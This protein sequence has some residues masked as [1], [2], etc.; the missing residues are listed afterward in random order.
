KRG[1]L[2]SSSSESDGVAFYI[3]L[4][5]YTSTSEFGLNVTW[6]EIDCG[7]NGLP[8]FTA[9][10]DGTYV[11]NQTSRNINAAYGN[12]QGVLL[13]TG[14]SVDL[15][16]SGNS[17][18]FPPLANGEKF[19]GWVK[20]P[21]A[22]FQTC[23]NSA[24][25]NGAVDFYDFGNFDLYF[26]SYPNRT[27]TITIDE[28][29]FY[30]PAF[31]QLAVECKPYVPEADIMN[32]S[33]NA[34]GTVSDLT[35]KSNISVVGTPQIG[36]IAVSHNG[37]SG[38]L[39]GLKIN[40]SGQGLI[41]TFPSLTTANAQKELYKNGFTVEAFAVNLSPSGEQGIIST[42]QNGGWGL[43]T[44]NADS[45]F[46]VNTANSYKECFS[47]AISTTNLT[48]YLG[49]YDFKNGVLSIY[50]NGV[51]NNKMSISSELTPGSGQAIDKISIGGD[52]DYYGAMT[53]S[54]MTNGIIVNAKVYSTVVNNIQ[55]KEIYTKESLKL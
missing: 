48:H 16:L 17:V 27:G 46:I 49:V 53:Q 51:L 36:S 41:A 38:A 4:T 3:D 20:I 8:V 35:Q 44:S 24:D 12:A 32:L 40:Q 45:K 33:F 37:K 22:A 43:F 7:S 31:K 50:I 23:W 15:P 47:S 25:A 28:F 39:N 10:S 26:G 30:G 42:C 14:E 1:N 13:S 11:E 52:V 5:N 54:L 34:N 21:F 9:N 19:K 18:T 29:S 6:H 55:A 2:V